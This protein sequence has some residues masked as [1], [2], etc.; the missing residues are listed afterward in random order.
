MPLKF[1][2]KKLIILI[3]MGGSIL[4]L[5][6]PVLAYTNY[7]PLPN[8]SANIAPTYYQ[9][10]ETDGFD[11]PACT[12]AVIQQINQANKAEGGEEIHLPP[13]YA[14]YSGAD[15]VFILTNLERLAFGLPPTPGLN[16][17]V[18]QDA[19]T[20]AQDL[21]DPTIAAS[22]PTGQSIWTWNSIWAEDINP[23][24]AVFNWL[25]NDGLGSGNIDCTTTQQEGCWGHRDN[26]LIDWDKVF[27]E[28]GW[29]SPPAYFTTAGAAD[30][31]LQ[32]GLSSMTELTIATD[33][34]DPVP[35]TTM[36]WEAI[37]ATYPSGQS[38][39]TPFSQSAPV[40][41]NSIVSVNGSSQQ[42]LLEQGVLHPIPSSALAS[43]FMAQGD[44]VDNVSTLPTLPIGGPTV[45]PF[46]SGTLVQA[47]GQP[48]VY[49]VINGVLQHIANPNVF[50]ANGYQWHQIHRI[51]TLEA[52]WPTGTPITSAVNP[53]AGQLIRFSGHSAIYID[54]NGQLHHIANPQVFE[55][56]G[57][58]WDNVITLS[59][60]SSTPSLGSP[61]TS[62]VTWESTGSLVRAKGRQAVYLVD[63]GTLDWITTAQAF[64]NL[65]AQWNMI[66]TVAALPQY[67]QGP[68]IV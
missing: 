65:G 15:Q 39:V 19:L 4:G 18:T 26:I 25:F 13:N 28:N 29:S 45:V 10:C 30:L 50:Y 1:L 66:Q 36:T 5:S 47:M 54:W 49:E 58:S 48:E 37:A 14:S 51:P 64:N 16:A 67:P 8:P 43:L 63:N 7:S 21:T 34:S 27:T 42:Y 41:D 46:P 23:A 12:T 9:T 62:A 56:N 38:P 61:V 11:S 24:S 35:S 31:A 32:N 6:I 22:L 40:L 68:N 17:T 60:G 44:A 52:F 59:D 55:E 3:T 57:W 53:V 33:G 2:T 20:G